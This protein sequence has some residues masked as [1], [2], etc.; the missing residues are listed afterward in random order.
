M[1]VWVKVVDQSNDEESI[2]HDVVNWL[3]GS[4]QNVQTMGICY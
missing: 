3:C 4:C 2:G 1:I